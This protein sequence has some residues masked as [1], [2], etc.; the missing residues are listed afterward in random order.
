MVRKLM[1]VFLCAVTV[2]AMTGC[3][4]TPKGNNETTA[5]EQALQDGMDAADNGSGAAGRQTGIDEG[6]PSPQTEKDS[7]AVLSKTKGIDIDLTTLSSTMVYAEVYNMLSH[8]D[9]YEGKKIKMTGQFSCYV[10]EFRGVNYYTC[11]IKD[12]AQCCSQ[13][14]E[15]V[16]KPKYDYPGDFPVEGGQI[17]VIGKFFTYT[18]G[19]FQQCALRNAVIAVG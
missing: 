19:D 18:E 13:G 6:A 1:C 2:L 11:I 3:G 10:D 8:P 14:L 5:V 7:N 4:G 12:A 9:E 17:T 15:F 16:P